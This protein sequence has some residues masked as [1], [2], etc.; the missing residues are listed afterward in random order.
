MIAP[1]VRGSESPS[2]RVEGF[3]LSLGL[4]GDRPGFRIR[5]DASPP[6]QMRE[7]EHS[8][9]SEYPHEASTEQFEMR[10]E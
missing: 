7:N 5:G 8:K 1:C 6:I 2:A 4:A 10:G 3:A 9:P